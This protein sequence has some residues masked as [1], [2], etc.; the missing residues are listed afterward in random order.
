MGLASCGHGVR[1]DE[2]R[3]RALFNEDAMD[4]VSWMRP[5]EGKAGIV[6]S[7]K[8]PVGVRHSL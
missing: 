4:V 6:V 8:S 1:G 7:S 5:C 2:D 3:E